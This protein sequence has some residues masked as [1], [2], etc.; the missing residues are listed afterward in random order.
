MAETAISP[1]V[2]IAVTEPQPGRLVVQVVGEIDAA[3]APELARALEPVWAAASARVV[4]DLSRVTFLGTAG[5]AELVRAAECAESAGMAL[6]LVG[7]T[8]CVD[9][10]INVAGLGA[11]LPLSP[12]LGHALDR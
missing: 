5:L 8:H 6:R 11:R 3:S 4:L 9:R 7:G 12:D 1:L 2:Q 10:A